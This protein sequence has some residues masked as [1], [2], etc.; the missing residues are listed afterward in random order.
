MGNPKLCSVGF[1]AALLSGAPALADATIKLSLAGE[2]FDGPPKFELRLDGKVIGSGVLD[3]AIDTGETGRLFANAK[4]RSYLQEFEFAVP[5]SQ[6]RKDGEISV[7]LT[8]DKYLDEEVGRDRNL[9]VDA[10]T[11]NGL[12]I[13]AADLKLLNGDKL[14]L[15]DYQAGLMPIYESTNMAVAVP[16]ATG[17]PAEQVIDLPEATPVALPV[18]LTPKPVVPIAR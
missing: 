6:F 1:T 9:F 13:V 5:E 15:L 3:K 4:P 17:W 2:A 10:I 8:N 12:E 7:I 18:K 11:V 16:P 14:Q